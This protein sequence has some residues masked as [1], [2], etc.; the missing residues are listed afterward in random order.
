LTPIEVAKWDASTL[1][2]AD[3][4][5]DMIQVVADEYPEFLD[6]QF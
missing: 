1:I 2:S 3:T 6:A 4:V 5:D